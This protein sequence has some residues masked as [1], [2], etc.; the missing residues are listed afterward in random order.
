ML[1]IDV[2]QKWQHLNGPEEKHVAEDLLIGDLA[3]NGCNMVA[4]S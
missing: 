1:C 4:S 2:S 3:D